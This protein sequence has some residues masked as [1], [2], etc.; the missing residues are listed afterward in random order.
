MRIEGRRFGAM[1]GWGKGM[2]FLLFAASAALLF[3]AAVLP[4]AAQE[5]ERSLGTIMDSYDSLVKQGM[6][7]VGNLLKST[8]REKSEVDAVWDDLN[9]RF[10]SVYSKIGHFEFDSLLKKERSESAAKKAS[11]WS[12]SMI[13]LIHDLQAVGEVVAWQRQ[14][15]RDIFQIEFDVEQAPNRLAGYTERMKDYGPRLAAIAGDLRTG[16]LSSAEIQRC[17]NEVQSIRVT[18]ENVSG[19][20]VRTLEYLGEGTGLGKEMDGRIGK[21]LED[22]TQMKDRHPNVAPELSDTPLNWVPLVKKHWE[23]LEKAREEFDKAYGPFLE[24]K[25]FKDIPVFREYEYKDLSRPAVTLEIELK[26]ALA[27]AVQKG[28]S[29]AELRRAIELDEELT[30]KERERIRKLDDSVSPQKYRELSLAHSRAAGGV[31]RVRELQLLMSR[32]PLDQINSPEYRKLSEESA[33][34]QDFKHPEQL[35]AERKIRDFEELSKK[36]SQER[37]TIISEHRNRRKK[38]DLAPEW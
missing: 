17:L 28:K 38:L 15:N 3:R 23:N 8:K 2:R 7:G 13:L 9:E 14:V 36:V 10:I 6:D 27:A 22:W 4:A 12:N 20:I 29:E 21:V 1:S 37:E 31:T 11:E 19:S 33:L 26:T 25:I 24:G 32:F 5:Q 35:A 18:A 16:K 30:R 34:I